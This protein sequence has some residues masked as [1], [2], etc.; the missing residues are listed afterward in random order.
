MKELKTLV[1]LEL[2]AIIMDCGSLG[3]NLF[4]GIQCFMNNEIIYGVS[5]IVM[6]VLLGVLVTLLICLMVGTIKAV[7][8][9]ENGN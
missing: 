5:H 8:E 2:F 7:K 1:W 3:V 9:K 6:V 4:N